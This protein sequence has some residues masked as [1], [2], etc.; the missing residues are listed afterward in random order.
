MLLRSVALGVGLAAACGLR[1]F[2]PLFVI[3]VAARQGYVTLSDGFAWLASRPAL[4]A[5]GTAT[6]VEVAAYH[7]PFLDNLLDAIATPSAMVAGALA[8][9]AVLT[10]L[11][12]HLKWTIAGIAGGGTA[13]LVQVATV[14]AR[15]GSTTFTGGL[16]NLLLASLEMF[17]AVGTVIIAIALPFLC[18][19]LVFVLLAAGVVLVVRRRRR[20]AV[21]SAQREA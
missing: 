9:A 19:L 6:V 13:G 5:L 21:R 8:T 20:R 11:P 15:V 16:G 12:P 18:L 10:D 3:G 14:L 17:G 2:L 4:V 1:V 7:V